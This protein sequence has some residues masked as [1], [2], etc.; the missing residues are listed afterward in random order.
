MNLAELAIKRPILIVM[1]V[2]S[3]L[4]LG[5]MGYTSIGVDMLPDVEYPTLTVSTVYEGASAEEIESLVTKP[6][7]DSLA[8]VEGLDTISSTSRENASIIVARFGLGVDVKYAET[9]VRDSVNKTK[10]SLPKDS[11]EPL[12]TRFSI[13]DAIP[14][15]VLSV[16]AKRDMASIKEVIDDKVTPE[17]EKVKGVG[18]VELFGGRDRAVRVRVDKSSLSARAV[19]VSQ[20]VEAIGME[21]VNYPA[22]RIKKPLQSVNVRVKGKLETLSD[23]ENINIKS[24]TGEI[25]RLR[26]LSTV[27]M[28]LTEETRRSRVDGANAI[29]FGIYK[30]SGENSVSIA[31][32]VRKKILEIQKNLP[33]DIVL[34]VYRD[35]STQIE[36]SI[37][38]LQEDVLLG[39]LSAMLI[40]WLFLGNF[41][42]TLITAVALP[43]SLLGAF[44][45][46][47]IAGFTKNMMTLLALSLSIGLLI[48]DSIVVREN[49][50]R[51]MEKGM[52]PKDAAVK[53]TNEVAMAV[54][55]TTLSIMAVFIPISFLQGVV[56]QFFK[57]FGVTIACALGIS[58]VD[59][60]TTAP[61]LSAYW[62]KKS[63]EAKN[64]A[65]RASK[66]MSDKWNVFYDRVVEVY[67]D[68]L[69]WALDK[70]AA[71]ITIAAGLF[72]A[73]VLVAIFFVGTSFLP[74]SD[75]H[76]FEFDMET[77]PGANL[78][79]I[80]TTLLKIEKYIQSIPEVE[81]YYVVAGNGADNKGR[82]F[83]SLKKHF[84]G[85]STVRVTEEAFD[86]IQKNFGKN[87]ILTKVDTGGASIV[88]GGGDSSPITINIT[89]S[90][91]R[92]LE[93]LARMVKK[94]VQET[95]GVSDIDSTYRPGLPEVTLKVD[96]EKAAKLGLST[97]EIG[98]FTSMLVKGKTVSKY[99][100]GDKEYDIILEM[101]DTDKADAASLKD[102]ILTNAKGSKIPLSAVCS[103]QYTSGPE[104][105]KRENKRRII[106]VTGN[107][108]EGYALGDVIKKVQ[109]NINLNVRFPDGYDYS[110]GGQ[111]T[112]MKETI[113]QMAKAMLLALLFMYMILASLYNSM[114]KPLILMISVPLA[115]IGALLALVMTGE[116]MDIMAMIGMLMV[117]GLVA[118]NGILLIDF[119]NQKQEE[120]FSAR[121][122]LLYAGPSVYGRFS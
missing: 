57:Q 67:R 66:M 52:T 42:S 108:R 122:A 11:D 8:T 115:I 35:P 59:A 43:N 3:L 70:K 5:L 25:I 18:S 81:G 93:N 26:D 34:Q 98:L 109:E 120:G 7:E 113:G 76:E 2:L 40:V 4:T 62:W 72:V 53:G 88:S 31:R 79:I 48:D 30:Q 29:I 96:R 61:M 56:G 82:L 55:A 51:Y 92:A 27:E 78:E 47:S 46:I 16:K 85:R 32:M 89:G 23:L 9:K 64:P 15:I 54:I 37:D 107:I 110:F 41:R 33:A 101:K 58:L 90:D 24:Y 87:L 118:K 63:S 69:K 112:Q 45:F 104:E 117:L 50:F 106:K 73:S 102:I 19:N 68:I 95:A 20:I 60:F 36:S 114:V 74:D 97:Y 116:K 22:G 91:I 6:L 75:Y 86:Y 14:V 80:D 100:A 21:N 94:A 39:A 28:G 119:T 38:G 77:Y 10:G 1:F 13:A 84:H 103:F 83:A 44:F 71:V 111:A 99:T 49:I 65:A 17:L 105:I 121:D 12:V